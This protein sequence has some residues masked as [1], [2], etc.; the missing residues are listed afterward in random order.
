MKAYTVSNYG[1]KL[2]NE[3][4]NSNFTIKKK[5]KELA[6]VANHRSN[7]KHEINMCVLSYYLDSRILIVFCLRNGLDY[8]IN[9]PPSRIEIIGN[10][11][12][13]WVNIDYFNIAKLFKYDQ[14]SFFFQ[15]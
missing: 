5:L 14:V 2:L 13:N 8:T 12:T 7:T 4:E 6:L 9:Y 3:L 1:Q 11:L 15:L 10:W